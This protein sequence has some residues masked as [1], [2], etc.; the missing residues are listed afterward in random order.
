MIALGLIGL[1]FDGY[2][3]RREVPR[4]INDPLLEETLFLLFLQA[5][6]LSPTQTF[7]GLFGL[8]Q[9]PSRA[10]CVSSRTSEKQNHRQV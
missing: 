3:H 7:E 2:E 10:S 4:Q 8:T 5:T 1:E 6:P 9:H